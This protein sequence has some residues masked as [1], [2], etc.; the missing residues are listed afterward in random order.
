VRDG[1]VVTIDVDSTSLSVEVED[2]ELR[3]RLDDWQPPPARYVNGVFARYRALVASAS[4]GAV[5]RP[6][7]T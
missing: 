5:L 1:D 2:A 6:H 7:G 4:E 3:K